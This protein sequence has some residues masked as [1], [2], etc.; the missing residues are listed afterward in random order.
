MQDH[1]S[2]PTSRS[3]VVELPAIPDGETDRLVKELEA[4]HERHGLSPEERRFLF[5]AYRAIF[6]FALTN[7]GRIA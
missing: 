2:S 5:H 3:Y 1:Q 7:A 4:F 6:T